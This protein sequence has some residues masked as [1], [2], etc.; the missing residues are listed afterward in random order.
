M[1]APFD[2]ILFIFYALNSFFNSIDV[3]KT[4]VKGSLK[5][6]KIIVEGLGKVGYF[7]AAALRDHGCKIIGVIEH[8]HSFYNA[9]GLDIDL[10]KK[11]LDESRNP[12]EYPNQKELKTREEFRTYFF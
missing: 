9:K 3:K 7:A 2:I 12:D 11:W 4:N 5:S 10:I 6:Q 8:H 1:Q